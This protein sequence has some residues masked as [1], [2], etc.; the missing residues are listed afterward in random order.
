MLVEVPGT[1]DW[2]RALSSGV[3]A[4]ESEGLEQEG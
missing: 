3:R 2:P 1:E 4:T